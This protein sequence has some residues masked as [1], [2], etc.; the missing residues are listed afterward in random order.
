M[1]THKKTA[2]ARKRPPVLCVMLYDVPVK[3]A[4]FK[5]SLLINMRPDF[6]EQ[7]IHLN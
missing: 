6:A 4:L 2:I 3:R 1:A 5:H 7:C